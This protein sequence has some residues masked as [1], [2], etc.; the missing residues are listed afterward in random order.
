MPTIH[1]RAVARADL[2]DHFVYLAEHAGLDTA[3]RFL[4]QE[5]ASKL[6]RLFGVLTGAC[7]P[8]WGH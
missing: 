1:Q 6:F 3:E 8:L 4:A 5:S 2:I 7:N